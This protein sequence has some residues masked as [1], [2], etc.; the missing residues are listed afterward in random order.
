MSAAAKQIGRTKEG[1][2]S[3]AEHIERTRQQKT[4]PSDYPPKLDARIHCALS[5]RARRF[6]QSPL[7][8]GLAEHAEPCRKA[9]GQMLI[10]PVGELRCAHQAVVHRDVSGARGG[11]GLLAAISR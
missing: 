1:S 10:H 8:S 7:L 11:D 9:L 2:S 6:T 5:A 4:N 3:G